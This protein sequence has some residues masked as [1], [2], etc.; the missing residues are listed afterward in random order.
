M[1]SHA[2]GMRWCRCV[3]VGRTEACDFTA[4]LACRLY[5]GGMSMS[6]PHV[7]R[8]RRGR[9]LRTPMFL[10]GIPARRTRR[11]EFEAVMVKI[12]GDF[13]RR[14]P[15]VQSIEFGFEDVPPSDPAPWEDHSHVLSRL[16]PADPKRGLKDRIVL[17]RLPIVMRAGSELPMMVRHLL[18]ERVNEV[19]I[20]PPDEFDA[21][22]NA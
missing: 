1:D 4:C 18:L 3:L 6:L 12:L 13:A 8:D 9:G 14:W 20:I 10:P 16:F 17:Y 22:L 15:G 21:A 11:E 5:S 7:F 19:L 2:Y